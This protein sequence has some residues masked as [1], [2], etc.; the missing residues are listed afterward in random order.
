MSHTPDV[1]AWV[2]GI[3]GSSNAERALAWHLHQQ[4]RS[5]AA[6]RHFA[7][8]GEFAPEDWTIRLTDPE[9]KQPPKPAE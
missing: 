6:A 3:D 7:R 1:G 8:A 2:V 4:G 5:D 9:S